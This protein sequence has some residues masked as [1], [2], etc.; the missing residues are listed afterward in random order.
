VLLPAAATILGSV[1]A[2]FEMLEV[3]TSLAAMAETVGCANRFNL[4]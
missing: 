2:L 3:V 4:V 1:T